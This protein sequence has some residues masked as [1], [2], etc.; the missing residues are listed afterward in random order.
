MQ[1]SKQ[2]LN[3]IV[4]LSLFYGLVSF[5]IFLQLLLMG[6]ALAVDLS[7]LPKRQKLLETAEQWLETYAISYAWGGSQLGEQEHCEQCNQCIAEQSPAP[8]QQIKDC[9]VCQK[10]SLDCSHFISLVYR[11]IGLAAP[12]LTTNMMRSSQSD[13]LE[14]RFFW[15]SLDRRIERVLPGDLL[16]YDGHVVLVTAIQAP[17]RGDVIHVTSGKQVRGPGQGIQRERSVWFDGFRGPV[18]RILRHKELH[19]EGVRQ[20]RQKNVIRPVEEAAL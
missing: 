2:S 18:K 3:Q 5:V 1:V 14:Q 12:Y 16:V 13:V 19:R 8:K 15:I 4:R 10:C 9:P 17:G 11:D 20:L 6:R 7:S